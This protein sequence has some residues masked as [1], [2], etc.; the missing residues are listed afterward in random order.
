M[1]YSFYE[2]VSTRLNCLQERQLRVV[3]L[4]VVEQLSRSQNS[5][6][7]RAKLMRNTEKCQ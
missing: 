2:R 7:W 6:Q 3:Q 5:V 1:V 4:R